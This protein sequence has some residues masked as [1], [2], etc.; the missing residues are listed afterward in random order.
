MKPIA[1]LIFATLLIAGP[2]WAVDPL[3]CPT[4]AHVADDFNGDGT[5]DILWHN[6][7]ADTYVIWF[8]DGPEQIDVVILVQDN[9]SLVLVA[10]GDYN[11]DC[12]TDML[13]RDRDTGQTFM[14]LWV[15]DDSIPPESIGSP[16]VK[17]RVVTDRQTWVTLPDYKTTE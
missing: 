8:M 17:W 2:A 14:W 13:W 3:V 7:E 10:T 15:G 6:I 11:G 9:V 16:P 12:T 4:G 5:T 1:A